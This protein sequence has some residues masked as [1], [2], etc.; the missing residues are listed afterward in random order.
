MKVLVAC[1]ESQ[2]VCRAF[3][4]R[5]HE[6]YSND[7]VDCSG[8]HPEWHLKMD[9]L[10][11]IDY[12]EWDLLIAHP[13]CTY[14]SNVGN[15][16]LRPEYNIQIDL[17][18]GH[19]T[20]QDKRKKDFEFLMQLMNAQVPKICVENPVGVVHS[21]FRNPDQIIHP[22]YFGENVQKRTCL[23]LKNLL[24]LKSTNRLPK[25]EPVAFWGKNDKPIQW[26]ESL[27]RHK[28]RKR[29]RSKTF[30]SIAKAMAS[31]WG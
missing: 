12:L 18:E 9:A 2:T 28:D 19:V 5:G 7:L 17:F 13:P 26:V 22:Y 16:Y 10:E 23:W 24:L 8:G 15:K 6:A 20:R 14:L 27:G 30:K 25:P 4:A 11:A 31:Q 3:R 1:E 29:L 21:W